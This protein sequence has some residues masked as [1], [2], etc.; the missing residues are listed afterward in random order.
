[1]SRHSR[2]A[3]SYQPMHD[4]AEAAAQLET[5]SQSEQTH[6]PMDRPPETAGYRRDMELQERLHM[7]EMRRKGK[8]FARKLSDSKL[9]MTELQMEML[10]DHLKESKL[11][12]EH[13]SV[14]GKLSAQ[15]AS[16]CCAALHQDLRFDVS[17]PRQ[18]LQSSVTELWQCVSTMSCFITTDL[19]NMDPL[20]FPCC[21][22][23]CMS[24]GVS[25]QLARISVRATSVA[26]RLDS[27]VS[28]L[29]LYCPVE[30]SLTR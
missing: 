19:V 23:V 15:S 13:S 18:R 30:H 11:W 10:K 3:N 4:L 24:V 25:F 29:L 6:V 1:M 14:M 7:E 12:N 20:G 27:P 9:A 17:F 8:E 5:D 2:S 28:G 21:S 26:N 16:D 22:V